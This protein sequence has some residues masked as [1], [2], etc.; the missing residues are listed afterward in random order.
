MFDYLQTREEEISEFIKQVNLQIKPFHLEI[1]KGKCE[2]TDK[3]YYVLANRANNEITLCASS[4][5]PTELEYFKQLVAK[6]AAD[7]SVSSINAL[8]LVSQEL[9]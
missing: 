3:S 2:I 8:H 9:L 6:I 7:E 1:K 4:Y 5:T